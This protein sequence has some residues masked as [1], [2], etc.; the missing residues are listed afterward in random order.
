VPSRRRAKTSTTPPSGAA[1][2]DAIKR[3]SSSL[4]ASADRERAERERTQRERDEAE[5][6]ARAAAEQAEAL[7]AAQRDLERAIERARD[8]RRS[9]SGVAE[10]DAA[11]RQAKARLI[12]LE[13]GAPPEW[14][15]ADE[16]PPVSPDGSVD[17]DVD[18]AS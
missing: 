18:Q 6:A 12:E 16:E 5:R 8:A 2:D 14:A 4:L 13:T 15:R 17:V 10:A 9:R 11:W 3:F 7:A 1:P